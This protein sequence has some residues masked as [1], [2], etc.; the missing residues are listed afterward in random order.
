M[1]NTI[2]LIVSFLSLTANT[3]QRKEE[4]IIATYNVRNCRGMDDKI[5][6]N[7]VADI[8]TRINPHLIALQEL[9]SATQRSSNAVVLNELAERTKMYAVYGASI[10]YQGG[11]YGIGVLSKEK[12]VGH[13]LVA[14][15]G[16]EENRS[17]LIV[18]FKKYVFCSTHFSLTKEDRIKSAEIIN[19]IFKEY[20][21][22]VFLA[23]DLNAT[24]DS[25]EIISLTDKWTMLSNPE[26]PTIPSTNPRKC[27]D[28]I[29]MLKN[30]ASKFNVTER[31]VG[32]EPLASDH[33][34]VWV[35]VTLK[36]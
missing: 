22:P 30:P 29:L 24:T 23:G 27:I 17:I 28:Y 14:L 25:Q 19:S 18:E 20:S 1:I 12:P 26:I 4:L 13:R 6:Y 32:N 15:P 7:R 34:P 16:R 5:D 10:D 2:L 33:L 21:K 11:K 8:I 35:R 9:D 36:R 3:S 31:V